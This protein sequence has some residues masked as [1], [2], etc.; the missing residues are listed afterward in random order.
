MRLIDSTRVI[1]RSTAIA[2]AAAAFLFGAARSAA[3]TLDDAAANYKTIRIERKGPVLIAR[4]YNP[5]LH[6]MN[7]AMGVEALNACRG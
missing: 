1:G 5:P 2:C 7:A 3:A 4:F 6:V